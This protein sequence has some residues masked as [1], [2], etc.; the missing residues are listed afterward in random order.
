MFAIGMNGEALT[1]EHGAP[2][3]LVMP[4]KYGYKSSKLIT[5]LTFLD[6]GGRGLV[7]RRHGRTIRRPATSCRASIIRSSSRTKRA[8][9][10]AARSS[11]TERRLHWLAE[12]GLLRTP[13]LRRRPAEPGTRC[14]RPRRSARSGGAT[15]CKLLAAC[16]ADW[17]LPRSLFAQRL[18]QRAAL[19][20]RRTRPERRVIV[21]TFGGGVR[22][23]DTLAPQG[24]VNIPHLAKEL[25]PQGLVY[26][27]ARYEGITGHFNSTGALVTGCR[28]EVDAYGSEAPVTP[29]IFELFRKEHG[30]PPE[31][32]WV[33]AT[34]KSVQPDGR[35][36]AA[37][38]RRSVLRQRHPAEAAADRDDQVGGEHR[39]RTRRRGSA[40]ARRAHDARRSTRAT[41]A[42]AGAC[43]SPAARS[44]PI[45]RRRWR[46]RCSTTSTIRA[47][48]PAATS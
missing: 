41:K 1:P 25:V 38:L 28:Q 6:K 21:V 23:E 34:N 40:G 43:S 4:F 2:L 13:K 24:W 3:R 9:S 31:E 46:S 45:S 16:M 5:K 35:Q 44:A 14:A 12:R 32:A 36:Q 18:R 39:R 48:R 10:R 27:R 29:T 20:R 47:C 7:S 22:Y 26:P 17:W 37:R 8:R 11:S 42:S 33:I 15:R 30:L 19:H